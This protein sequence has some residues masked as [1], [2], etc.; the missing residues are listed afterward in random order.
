MTLD[1]MID[2]YNDYS[3]NCSLDDFKHMPVSE[4]LHKR[5]DLHAFL[6]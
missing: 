2:I 1:E 5:E 6:L 3:E 4:K